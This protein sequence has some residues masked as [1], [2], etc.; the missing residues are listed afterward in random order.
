MFKNY[1]TVAFRSLMK[2]K[3]YSTINV[4][5]LAIGIACVVLIL[6]F[7]KDEL[8]YD[9]YH[10]N[11]SQI[12]RVTLEWHYANTPTK[13][14][15]ST[16]ANLAS[17]LLNDVPGVKHAVRFV[18]SWH[19]SKA[20]Y[21]KSENDSFYE[22]Q[23]Y[24]VDADIF[25]IF[26]FPFLK[27]D[28]ET[29]LKEP[30]SIVITDQLS[31]RYFGNQDPLGKTLTVQDTL[32]FKVTGVLAPI[33][34][35]SHFTFDFLISFDTLKSLDYIGVRPKY[36]RFGNLGFYTYILLAESASADVVASQVHEITRRYIPEWEAKNKTRFYHMLQPLSDIHLHSSHLFF[37]ISSHG[38]VIYIYTFSS[39]A[40]L[41]LLIACINFMNLATARSVNRAKEV[42][43]RKVVGAYRK[44]LIR[45]FLGE[46]VLI[47]VV[48]LCIAV[49][50]IELS[51][52]IFSELTE[53]NL[54]LFEDGWI[55]LSLIG[56]VVVVGFIAGSHPAFVLSKFEPVAV[57][58]GALKSD[59]RGLWMRKS[60][61]AFQF[62]IT[63]TLIISTLVVYKQLNHMKTKELGFT[64]DQ[65]AV[66]NLRQ[67]PD[68]QRRF[69][70]MKAEFLKHPGVH[71]AAGSATIPGHFW[72]D[73]NFRVN[74]QAGEE[75]KRLVQQAVDPDYLETYGMNLVAGRNFSREF[76]TDEQEAFILN[77]TAVAYLGWSTP[78]EA[79]GKTLR[80]RSRSIRLIGV[81]KDF[82]FSS[83]QRPIEPYII[84]TGSRGIGYISLKVSTQDIKGTLSALETTW[85]RLVP[86]RPFEFFFLDEDFNRQYRSEE[87]LGT[88]FNAFSMLAIVIA[89]LGLLG[90]TSFTAQQR[91]KEIGIRKTLGASVTDIALMLSKE[92]MKPVIV[93]SIISW[94]L[95][96]YAMETWL[97]DFAYK[98]N[99]DIGTFLLG[100]MLAVTIALSA[101]AY[102]A[103]KAA[104]T[105]P[106]DALRYK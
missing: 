41:V 75:M 69:E 72:N 81:V 84:R 92:F 44:Q 43:I 26:T 50:F 100:G 60:L 93:A 1:L 19:W 48:A 35:H 83:L 4:I 102:Q 25:N 47:S 23:G 29:A 37:D 89:C 97:R 11:A 9:A 82:H 10:E 13:Y 68:L 42:G 79:L 56:L 49:G 98:I 65:I 61:V 80:W 87:R 20:L 52:P 18:P 22:D 104:L 5:G 66:I 73:I 62:I 17:L 32:A 39:I 86:G 6:L 101:V 55:T 14:H 40:V 96:Y 3:V 88:I 16:S 95:A 15:A 76:S 71:H 21:I 33:P 46:S 64:K 57:L 53:K 27:G 51:A 78:Q 38:S 67:N 105:N 54:K 94:P 34:S 36:V 77:E 103:V 74:T 24:F 59:S 106:V 28:P 99:L 91:I 7:V 2:H 58:K 30:F 12:Y 70:A 85:Q 31:R 45:Q 8:S 63:I 90:L